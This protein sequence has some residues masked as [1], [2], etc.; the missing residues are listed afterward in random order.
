MKFVF[1]KLGFRFCGYFF[2]YEYR[3]TILIIVLIF[4]DFDHDQVKNF[5]R[6][7]ITFIRPI[8]CYSSGSTKILL[9]MMK[10]LSKHPVFI[11]KITTTNDWFSKYCR[12]FLLFLD[13]SWKL[14]ETGAAA[15]RPNLMDSNTIHFLCRCML[16]FWSLKKPIYSQ[17]NTKQLN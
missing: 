12:F 17:E 9:K 8:C 13:S 11:L 16:L 14:N 4:Q 1:Y 6:I 3:N 15:G 5:W 10:N 7:L 2:S